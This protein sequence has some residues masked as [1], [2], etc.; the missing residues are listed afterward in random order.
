MEVRNTHTP[1]NLPSHLNSEIAE[2]IGEVSDEHALDKIEQLSPEELMEFL[3]CSFHDKEYFEKKQN[4]LKKIWVK[5]NLSFDKDFI[6]NYFPNYTIVTSDQN[7]RINSVWLLFLE[8]DF[9]TT[10]VQ[11]PVGNGIPRNIDFSDLDPEA[12]DIIVNFLLNGNLPVISE[13]WL[14]QEVMIKAH[15]LDL[16]KLIEQLPEK[17]VIKPE[18]SLFYFEM[19][20]FYE[21]ERFKE[22]ALCALTCELNDPVVAKK[23][24]K[25]AK[26][27][28]QIREICKKYFLDGLAHQLTTIAQDEAQAALFKTEVSGKEK[29]A[30]EDP[31][32]QAAMK[33]IVQAM[34]VLDYLPKEILQTLNP[35]LLPSIF[36]VFPEFVKD[37]N[38]SV[39]SDREIANLAEHLPPN[40]IA[41]DLSGTALSG[42]TINAI[43][44]CCPALESINLAGAMKW[45]PKHP[46]KPFLENWSGLA[47]FKNLKS[48]DVSGCNDA[49]L[50][51]ESVLVQ[52]AERLEVLRMG[53]CHLNIVQ[54]GDEDT[55]E[56][57]E[58]MLFGNRCL[59][60]IANQG[61]KLRELDVSG[62]EFSGNTLQKFLNEDLYKNLEVL[63]LANNTTLNGFDLV[64]IGDRFRKLRVLN[65]ANVEAL[66]GLIL[67]KLLSKLGNYPDEECQKSHLEELDISGLIN[68]EKANC[69]ASLV[70]NAISNNCPNL[71]RLAFLNLYNADRFKHCSEMYD[72]PQ[73]CSQ[74][75]SIQGNPSGKIGKFF[76]KT[77]NVYVETA[78]PQIT[79][80]PLVT[81]Y[82]RLLKVSNTFHDLEAL[83]FEE[84][85]YFSGERIEKNLKETLSN[86][87]KLKRL[88]IVIPEM[89][90]KQ[91]N[92]HQYVEPESIDIFEI[93]SEH[94]PK[95][96]QVRIKIPCNNKTELKN[97]V[98]MQNLKSL[99]VKNDINFFHLHNNEFSMPF[100]KEI[101][102]EMSDLEDFDQFFSNLLLG[103][104]QLEII[105][106]NISSEEKN[107]CEKTKLALM[108]SNR[109]KKIC[110][111]KIFNLSVIEFD[112]RF[113]QELLAANPRLSYVKLNGRSALIRAPNGEPVI[114]VFGNS[115]SIKKRM[116]VLS[117]KYTSFKII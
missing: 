24:Y 38:I 40:L 61:K 55:Y 36:R 110:L 52:N 74:L 17:C 80:L 102:L 115:K 71:R 33:F 84:E 99:S 31:S 57:F 67:E 12:A 2:K 91:N 18:N 96:E 105:D 51:L 82:N 76:R 75:T 30:K 70:F 25:I 88:N 85:Q 56:F 81:G 4:L 11:T 16:R 20:D 87:P 27:N 50:V 41:L 108:Q 98:K 113:L 43:A 13:Q 93:L 46:L 6:E 7:L 42:A 48:I 9:F 10:L 73:Q 90:F 37:L 39:Y 109:L 65:L 64:E 59:Y 22:K 116:Q 106:I 69:E 104:P 78:N 95:L 54:W 15:E 112:E 32:V 86:L 101:S 83:N 114:K 45:N 29:E 103:S 77:I 63:S 72:L 94:C 5:V 62:I 23:I 66:D 58:D 19:G 107:K 100:L 47:E 8:S 53:N 44:A 14:S 28:P 26:D 92:V 97:L 1:F 89:Q 3:D 68:E 21:I 35:E 34:K 60:I 111:D 117:Q 79:E 49:A